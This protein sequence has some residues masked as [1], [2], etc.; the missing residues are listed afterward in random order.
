MAEELLW[1]LLFLKQPMALSYT[2]AFW[3]MVKVLLSQLVFLNALYLAPALLALLIHGS[4]EQLPPKQVL[5]RHRIETLACSANSF[6]R[7]EVA[8]S[9]NSLEGSQQLYI[10]ALWRR[11]GSLGS[12][13][14]EGK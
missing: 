7:S 2:A 6:S 10:A 9:T 3:M 8:P 11:S 4:E 13:V 14:C 1:L 5:L 12:R